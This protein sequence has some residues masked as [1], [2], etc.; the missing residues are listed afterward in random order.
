VVPMRAKRKTPSRVSGDGG[1][2]YHIGDLEIGLRLG[3]PV[4]QVV[5]NNASLGFEYHLQ[6]HEHR[7]LCN[8]AHEYLDVDFANVAKGFGCHGER[9]VDPEKLEGALQRATDA[10][11]PA[12]IDIVI[13][14][15]VPASRD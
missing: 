7:E 3:L 4:I 10:G 13:S 12:I 6:Q 14:R 1:V 9:V 2:G 5:M 11:K 8:E 15:E